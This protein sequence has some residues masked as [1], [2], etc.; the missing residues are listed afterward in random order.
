MMEI[1]DIFDKSKKE[2]KYTEI[3]GEKDL[4]PA[5]SRQYDSV[6]EVVKSL[7]IEIK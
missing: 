6:R 5:T 3:L 7:N 4:M 1:V 2:K